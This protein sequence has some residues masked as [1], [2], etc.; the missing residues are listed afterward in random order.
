[1][2]RILSSLRKEKKK[3]GFCSILSAHFPEF[4]LSSGDICCG[5]NDSFND[6]L[7]DASTSFTFNKEDHSNPLLYVASDHSL[8]SIPDPNDPHLSF[9]YT[10]FPHMFPPIFAPPLSQLQEPIVIN[11]PNSTGDFPP[12]ASVSSCSIGISPSFEML[13]HPPL[14]PTQGDY[15]P[16][17]TGGPTQH[18]PRQPP[19]RPPHPGQPYGREEHFMQPAPPI[20]PQMAP[21]ARPATSNQQ[22]GQVGQ[23]MASQMQASISECSAQPPPPM[24]Q[25]FVDNSGNILVHMPSG[26]PAVLLPPQGDQL[27][28]VLPSGIPRPTIVNANPILCP[29]EATVMPHFPLPPDMP[30]VVTPQPLVATSQIQNPLV[31]SMSVSQPPCPQPFLPPPSVV[32]AATSGPGPSPSPAPMSQVLMAPPS[33]VHMQQP[34][35]PVQAIQNHSGAAMFPVFNQVPLIAVDVPAMC[36]T[37]PTEANPPTVLSNQRAS[38]RPLMDIKVTKE[39]IAS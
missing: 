6:S 12:F 18:Y 39:D 24:Q 33:V 4:H 11:V 34:M 9:Y 37:M 17:S 28:Q 10:H 35:V 23:R 22:S 14:L 19:P 8:I 32:M 15:I 16:F 3:Q 25:S 7:V 30:R 2:K 38:V 36:S 13:H 20:T 5:M 31:L 29:L 21:P 26:H 1:M 27:V